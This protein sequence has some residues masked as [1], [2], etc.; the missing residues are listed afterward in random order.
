MK[1]K[2]LFSR[3]SMWPGITSVFDAAEGTPAANDSNAGDE[4]TPANTGGGASDEAGKEKEESVT[5]KIGNETRQVTHAELVELATKS[6]GADARFEE[7]SAIR[8]EAERGI[9]IGTLVKELDEEQ[10]EAS[11][12][13]LAGLLDIDPG[14]FMANLNADETGGKSEDK[15]KSAEGATAPQIDSITVA[16]VLDQLGLNPAEVKA[17]LDYSKQRHINDA[18]KEIRSTTDIA[19]DSD[20]VFGKIAVGDKKDDRLK[21]I[22]E[23]VAEDVLKR[24]TDGDAFG[25]DLI[26]ASVQ[27]IRARVTQMGIPDT[28]GQHPITLGLLPG[29]GILP[30]AV[31]SDEPIKRVSSADDEDEDNVIA[32][33]LQKGI[34]RLHKS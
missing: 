30:E 2:N 8:K 19:V 5:I 1:F 15:V 6:A 9:R 16:A 21:V 32:R 13:E 25:A 3:Y 14:A 11:I 17:T 12:R 4:E 34:R 33:Y 29:G 31:N 10:S 22:K 20:E 24:I 28:S 7:A 27:K 26:A 23:M 18:R